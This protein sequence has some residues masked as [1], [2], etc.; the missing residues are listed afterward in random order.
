MS[1]SNTTSGHFSDLEA[2]A[3]ACFAKFDELRGFL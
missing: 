2:R 1:P 3:R